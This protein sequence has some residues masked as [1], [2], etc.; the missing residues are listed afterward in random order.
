MS[1]T[2]STFLFELTNFLLL[3]LLL[4]WLLFKP[5]RSALQTRQAT[6]KQQAEDLA[7]RTAE[8][9]R[10]RADLGQRQRSLEEDIADVRKKRLA[11]A[12]QEAD[13]LIA[14]AREAAERE[15]DAVKHGLARLERAQLERLSAA[16]A[17]ATRESIARLLATLNAP[18]IDASLV[19][20][21]CRELE[22]LQGT[23]LGPVLIE[24]ARPLA[25]TTRGT[26]VAALNA[27]ASV[28]EFR[29]VPDLGAG[30]RITTGHGLIDTS[31]L[32]L[33]RQAEGLVRE[34]LIAE[35][36]EVTT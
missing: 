19:R 1:P 29:V 28:A 25:D 16:V 22:R 21:A 10:L 14:R 12:A 36:F 30:I 26:I 6:A 31:A 24:S 20:A 23:G 8:A 35:S 32:G 17:V 2:V 15:R 7:M 34:A 4:G 27:H 11:A 5:V 13:A 33:A 18:D 3:A 9:E